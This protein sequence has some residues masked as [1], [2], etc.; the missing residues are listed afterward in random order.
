MLLCPWCISASHLP[1]IGTPNNNLYTSSF[2]T[3]FLRNT[4][5]PS[6]RCPNTF[7][8]NRRKH[9]HPSLCCR[10]LPCDRISVH[11]PKWGSCL[12]IFRSIHT[13]HQHTLRNFH[14]NLARDQ[15][16]RGLCCLRLRCADP[17]AWH[18]LSRRCA[19]RE[20]LQRLGEEARTSCC[21][22]RRVVSG[23]LAK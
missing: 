15:L 6:P 9:V 14:P 17:T 8:P 13:I 10:S 18:R 19:T 5:G 11:T 3:S 20:Q 12:C 22:M 21:L 7:H 4:F 2:G 1:S 16:H 23:M